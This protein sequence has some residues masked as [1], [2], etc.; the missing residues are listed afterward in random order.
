MPRSRSS[1]SARPTARA[2][3]S[4]CVCRTCSRSC[5]RTTFNG[6]VEG[7]NDLNAQYTTQMFPQFADQVGRQLRPGALGHLLGVPLDDRPRRARRARRG[8][9]AV[10]HPQEG[11]A[12]GAAVGVAARDLGV[13]GSLARHPRRLDL[14]RDGPPALDRLQPHAHAGRRLAERA[15]VDGAHLARRVHRDLRRARGRRDRAHRED[16]EEGAGPTART[17]TNPIRARTR[18][19]TPPTTVY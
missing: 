3:S 19:K 1:R 4:R 5:R 17:R 2:S 15:R 12:R 8:R 14:H 10:A 7:I 11:E 6:C 9:R 18:S 13:A 16:R